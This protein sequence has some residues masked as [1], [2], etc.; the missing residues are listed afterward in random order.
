MAMTRYVIVRQIA[1]YPAVADTW[2]VVCGGA[3]EHVSHHE[4]EGEARSAVARYKAG[5]KRRA[6][7][8]RRQAA[9]ASATGAAL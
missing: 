8:A 1:H 4:T 7:Q 6:A 5:D 2:T 9:I 3:N